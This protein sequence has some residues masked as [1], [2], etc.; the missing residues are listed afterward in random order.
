MY[1]YIY[2]Y[3]YICIDCVC[4]YIYKNEQYNNYA[5]LIFTKQVKLMRQIFA[6]HHVSCVSPILRCNVI[7]HK[8]FCHTY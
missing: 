6:L 3:I 7:L 5:E 8:I 4:I 2:M 1:I